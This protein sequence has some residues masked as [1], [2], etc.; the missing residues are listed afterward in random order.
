MNF[1]VVSLGP[2]KIAE[3][4]A[5]GYNVDIFFSLNYDFSRYDF[6]VV[7]LELG[8]LKAEEFIK[9]VEDVNCKMLIFCILP[10]TLEKM[11]IGRRQ[12]EKILSSLDFEGAIISCDFSLEEKI[13]AIRE[14]INSKL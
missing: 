8:G 1:A 6:I 9:S 4:I 14:L 11:I 2:E 5:S 10:S 3:E 7:I 13:F 12:A